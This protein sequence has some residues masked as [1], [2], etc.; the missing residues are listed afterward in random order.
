ML[1]DYFDKVYCIHLP[2]DIRRKKIEKQ[3][4]SVG[5]TDVQYIH[6]RPPMPGF[7]MNNM[8]RNAAGELG[9][10]MSHIKAAVKAIADRAIRPIFFE[11]D[12]LFRSGAVKVMHRVLSELPVDYGV[13]YLGGHPREQAHMVSENLAQ[14]GTFSFAEAYSIRDPL[15]WIDFWCSRIGQKNAMVDMILGEFAAEHKSFCVYP[16]I[17]RQ[18]P[19]HSI[20]T[21]LDDN[22]DNCLKKGWLTNLC[23]DVSS[24]KSA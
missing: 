18:P 9:C 4:D 2:D 3:F 17:T 20:I 23:H 7:L 1:L 15:A 10:T 21:G 12:I 14:I 5:I 8:R 6:A 11:D 13:L 22:K 24:I 16:T 19:G